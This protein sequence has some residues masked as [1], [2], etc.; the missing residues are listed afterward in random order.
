MSNFGEGARAACA[1]FNFMYHIELAAS[2]PRWL[3]QVSVVWQQ[4]KAVHVP[5]KKKGQL[6]GLDE[7]LADAECGALIHSGSTCQFQFYA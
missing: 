7:C 5:D 1:L 2:D 3:C 4:S 6:A